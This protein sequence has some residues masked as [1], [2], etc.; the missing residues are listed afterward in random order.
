MA[1]RLN[2]VF[3]G[4]AEMKSGELN[5]VKNRCGPNAKGSDR[6]HYRDVA[7]ELPDPPRA[8]ARLIFERLGP[9]PKGEEAL[10]QYL[11]EAAFNR[12]SKAA[13]QRG[14][15]LDRL[16]P[17]GPYNLDNLRYATPSEQTGNRILDRDRSVPS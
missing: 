15:S 8:A 4:G 9:I 3:G 14:M 16:D 17:R 11:G 6:W 5:G 10:R 2:K 12:L 7:Y 13:R 1:I